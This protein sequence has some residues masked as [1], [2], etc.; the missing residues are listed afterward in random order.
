M[1]QTVVEKE[2]CPTCRTELPA[3]AEFCYHCGNSVKAEEVLE[4]ETQKISDVW[5]RKDIVEETE[6]TNHKETEVSGHKL[7]TAVRDIDLQ[8]DLR[9]FQAK[10]EETELKSAASLRVKARK[11]PT[12]KVEVRWEEHNNAPNVWF[13]AGAGFLAVLTMVIFILAMYLR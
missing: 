10:P 9:D 3:T 6:P 7:E 1:S 12:K 11:V 4:N 2:N 8:K 13:I 5:L